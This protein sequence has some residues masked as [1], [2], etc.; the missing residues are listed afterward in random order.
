MLGDIQDAGG[1]T[2]ASEIHAAGGVAAHRPCDVTE[3]AE[4]EALVNAAVAEYGRLDILVNNAAAWRRGA[5]TET[6]LDDWVFGRSSILDATYDGCKAAI[7]QMIASGGGSII[8]LSSVNGLL[9]ARNSAAYEAAKGALIL[10][11][12]EVACDYGPHGIRANCVCPGLIVTEKTAPR[13]AANPD[14]ARFAAAISPPRRYGHPEDIANAALFLASDNR[15][16]S[17]ATPSS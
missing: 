1:A 4:V 7:P 3:Y 15:R 5:V 8:S 16:S 6:S 9:A 10:P 14:Q 12:K 2:T 17:P 13:M 11:M